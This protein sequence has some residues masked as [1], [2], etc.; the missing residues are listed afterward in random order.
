[1]ELQIGLQV[2]M[3]GG[4]CLKMLIEVVV[5]VAGNEEVDGGKN[6]RCYKDT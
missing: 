4:D 5:R 2:E 6:Y 3:G 1:V